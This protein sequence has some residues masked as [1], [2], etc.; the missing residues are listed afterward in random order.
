MILICGPRLSIESLNVPQDIELRQFVPALYEHF[1]ACDLAI[2]QGGGTTTLELT[3]LRR[4]FIFF[5]LEGHSEQEIVVAGR[6]RRYGAG[7]RMSYSSTTEKSLA[8]AIIANIN[9]MKTYKDVPVNGA[10]A[11]A[12]FINKL[13]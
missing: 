7:I 10:N 5:P 4:P 2:V 3:A 1:A 11:G 9:V 12:H 8:E 6:L 13:L